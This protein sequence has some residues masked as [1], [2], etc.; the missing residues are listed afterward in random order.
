MAFGILFLWG[1]TSCG[2]LSPGAGDEAD[3]ALLIRSEVGPATVTTLDLP[4]PPKGPGGPVTDDGDDGTTTT[5]TTAPIT[6]VPAPDLD[7]VF[8][9]IADRTALTDEGRDLLA[10]SAPRLI[11]TSAVADECPIETDLLLLGCYRRR[12]IVVLDVTDSRLAGMTETTTAHELLHAAWDRLDDEE[13]GQLT[14]LLQSAYDR[15]TDP[16][17]TAR[18]DDYRAHDPSS[19]P[20]E[21]HSILGTEVADLG[22]ELEHHYARWFTDR[23]QVVGLGVGARET[24]T[25]L[26]AQVSAMDTELAGRWAEVE[27]SHQALEDDLASLDQEYA[28]LEALAGEGRIAEH[29]AGVGPYNEHVDAYNQAVSDYEALADDYNELV[30]ERNAVAAAYTELIDQISTDG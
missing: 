19:V 20:N 5:S 6:V 14:G 7:P 8:A 9:A 22:P 24:L 10:R 1:S 29:D 17:L 27:A 25:G 11:D 23:H 12:Q 30:D 26:D 3:G 21:L 2:S 4:Q 16:D 13:R 18:I 28:D 15:L